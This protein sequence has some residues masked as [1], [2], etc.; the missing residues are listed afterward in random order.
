MEICSPFTSV[1]SRLR[2]VCFQLKKTDLPPSLCAFFNLIQIWHTELLG[3]PIFS[4]F[5]RRG[6]TDLSIEQILFVFML[7]FYNVHGEITQ[8]AEEGWCFATVTET[9]P[10]VNY[11]NYCVYPASYASFCSVCSE[12]YL[13]HFLSPFPAVGHTAGV[14]FAAASYCSLE[15]PDTAHTPAFPAVKFQAKSIYFNRIAGNGRFICGGEGRSTHS[16]HGE[17]RDTQKPRFQQS[18]FGLV[19]LVTTRNP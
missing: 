17:F 5:Q 18:T 13:C 1:W 2:H 10:E 9:V 14:N 15:W 19:P 6:G 7:L 16:L 3:S 12:L 8:A 11:L 4:Q